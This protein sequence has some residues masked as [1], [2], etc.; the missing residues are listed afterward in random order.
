MLETQF[1][2]VV[3]LLS[4]PVLLRPPEL[5]HSRLPCPSLSP[6]VCSNLC[7]LVCHPTISLPVASFSWA[8]TFPAL[9]SLPMSQLLVLGAQIIGVSVQILQSKYFSISPSNEYS[10]W[11]PFKID[12]FDLLVVQGTLNSLLQH[13][14][15]KTSI[16]F[17]TQ[18]SLYS[19]S[20]IHMYLLEKP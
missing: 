10:G 12:C 18:P 11:I 9:K 6:R 20:H 4:C 7:L 15:L 1:V 3:K 17:G 2:A 19:K 14:G 13:N 8:Q 16:L 5:Q